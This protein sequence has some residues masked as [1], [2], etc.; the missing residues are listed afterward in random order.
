VV[1]LK[2]F[3]RPDQQR[4]L[5]EGIQQAAQTYT[6]TR[7]RNALSNFQKIMYYNCKTTPPPPHTHDNTTRHDTH[8]FLYTQASRTST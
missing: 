4:E 5:F 2:G 3:L 1:H 7:A 6:P 8:S